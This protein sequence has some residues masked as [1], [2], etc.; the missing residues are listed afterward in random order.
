MDIYA[1]IEE[2]VLDYNVTVNIKKTWRIQLKLLNKL[3]EVCK[4]HGI[5]YFAVC[6][7][8]LGAV[9]HNGFIPWDDDMDV[10]LLREDYDKLIFH[11]K[12]EFE[13]PFFLQTP[14]SEPNRHANVT[15]LRYSEST[16][17][18]LRDRHLNCNNG[19]YIDVFPFD[20]VADGKLQRNLHFFEI[21]VCSRLLSHTR[22]FENQ[23]QKPLSYYIYSPIT[24]LIGYDRLF[25]HY[26]KVCGKYSNKKTQ[27]MGILS[28]AKKHTEFWYYRDDL[29]GVEY[30]DF[31][32]KKIPIPIGYDGCL[33][34]NYGNYME[35]PPIEKRGLWHA[36][37]LVID[38]ETPYWEFQKSKGWI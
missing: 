30:I 29:K 21:G 10:G 31:E 32:D 1:D 18:E 3:E 11:L 4:K 2:K 19:I 26:Q 8:L 28:G 37:N 33:K 9:R 35:L 22:L 27:R 23:P 6:G 36:D 5:S 7:T 24:K 13:Y 34:V 38:P 25:K 14:I 15:R 12:D 20:G 17:I 16:A